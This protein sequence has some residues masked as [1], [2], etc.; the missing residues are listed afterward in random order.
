MTF[1]GFSLAKSMLQE[2]ESCIIVYKPVA[3]MVFM[4]M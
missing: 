2:P 3:Y 1:Y 4:L